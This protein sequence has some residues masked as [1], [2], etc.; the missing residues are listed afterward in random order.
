MALGYF[1]KFMDLSVICFDLFVVERNVVLNV[2][3][4]AC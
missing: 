3:H 4:I 1:F 2:V